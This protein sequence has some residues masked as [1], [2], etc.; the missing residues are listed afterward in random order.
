MDSYPRSWDYLK[1]KGFLRILKIILTRVGDFWFDL[2]YGTDTISRIELKDLDFDSLNKSTGEPYQPTIARSFKKLLRMMNLPHDGVFVD[3]G[4][5]K[6]R[7]LL[8]ASLYGFKRVVGVEFSPQL[9]STAR[10]NIEKFK[11]KTDIDLN[12]EVIESDAND[13][14]IR[15]DEDIFFLSNPFDTTVLHNVLKSLKQSLSESYRDIWMIY[16]NPVHSAFIEKFF[17]KTNHY[18]IGGEDFIV[19]RNS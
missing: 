1:G 7:L 17:T 12:I 4:S 8:L 16:Y 9:C 13:Y 6:G 10:D 11:E 3:L 19:Y 5:G 18:I 15:D 14:A 2:R